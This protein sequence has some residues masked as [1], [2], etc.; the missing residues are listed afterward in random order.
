MIVIPHDLISTLDHSETG[1]SEP[2]HSP[3][4]QPPT[5]KK[6]GSKVHTEQEHP[7][8]VSSILHTSSKHLASL[9]SDSPL[10]KVDHAGGKIV[11]QVDPVFMIILLIILLIL[12]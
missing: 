10:L 11:V 5:K 6:T 1:H 12:R 7:Q 2:D 9:A 8:E 3:K 4:P